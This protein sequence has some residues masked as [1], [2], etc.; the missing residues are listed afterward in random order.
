MSVGEPDGVEFAAR[1]YVLDWRAQYRN[2]SKSYMEEGVFGNT[3]NYR[4]QKGEFCCFN[5][6]IS[7]V[8]RSGFTEGLVS[9]RFP[10]NLFYVAALARRITHT[11][12]RAR[13]HWTRWSLTKTQQCVCTLPC[14]FTMV[15]RVSTKKPVSTVNFTIVKLW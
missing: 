13:T 8:W 11:Y 4:H 10:N 2:Q 1:D 14:K 6:I 7:S 9:L 3:R 5:F 12:T 15:T